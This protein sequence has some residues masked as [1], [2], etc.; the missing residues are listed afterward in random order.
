VPN[1]YNE[2]ID[3]LKSEGK[4][5]ESEND[6]SIPIHELASWARELIDDRHK[7]LAFRNKPIVR[8]FTYDITVRHGQVNARCKSKTDVKKF[9]KSIRVRESYFSESSKKEKRGFVC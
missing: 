7:S 8:L 9:I 5:T 1:I 4:K 3:F 2:V 6:K